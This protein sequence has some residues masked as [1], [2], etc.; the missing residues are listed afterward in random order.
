MDPQS[1][2]VALGYVAVSLAGRRGMVWPAIS[3]C[4][5]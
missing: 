3:L 2:G 4:V 1:S 5:A